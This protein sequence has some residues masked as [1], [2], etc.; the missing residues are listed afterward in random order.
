MSYSE[1]YGYIDNVEG[2]ED[3]GKADVDIYVSRLTRLWLYSILSVEEFNIPKLYQPMISFGHFCIKSC[4]TIV[5]R[6]NNRQ[7]IENIEK[8]INKT[9][10]YILRA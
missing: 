10:T 1:R 9:Y 4:D 8:K 3:K 2:T 6:Q 7:S 5:I